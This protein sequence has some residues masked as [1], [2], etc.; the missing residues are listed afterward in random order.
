M[1][2]HS[3]LCGEG[4]WRRRSLLKYPNLEPELVPSAGVG[5]RSW[6][7]GRTKCPR[8]TNVT[9]IRLR[10]VLGAGDKYLN[11]QTPDGT[12]LIGG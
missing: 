6:E 11:M 12:R 7:G 3:K 1:V 9:S 2:G 10:Y 8:R 4:C 5:I